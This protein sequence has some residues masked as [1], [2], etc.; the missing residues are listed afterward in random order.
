MEGF[1]RILRTV[2]GI[3][4]GVSSASDE[5]QSAISTVETRLPNHGGITSG[6][7]TDIFNV[8]YAAAAVVAVGFIIW[9]GIQY[10]NS[11]GDAGKAAK[12]KNTIVF[13]IAGLI[14]VL[15]ASVITNIALEVA[16]S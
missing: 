10:I 13:A 8:A 6:N 11:A 4:D 14:V 3:C 7:I 16:A 1:F 5:C 9:G 15:L 2:G 12:A